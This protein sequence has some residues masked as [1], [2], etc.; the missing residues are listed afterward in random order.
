M[1][2]FINNKF[3]L[4]I[5]LLVA[6]ILGFGNSVFA[7]DFTYNNNQYSF[8]EL[9]LFT[10]Y[11]NYNY[12]VIIST[13]TSNV[14]YVC[15]TNDNVLYQSKYSS[16]PVLSYSKIYNFNYINNT[17]SLI[18]SNGTCGLSG[19][20]NILW[21]DI[22]IVNESGNV[23]FQGA[24]QEVTPETPEI[25]TTLVEQATQ[26]EMG[27]TLLETIK[28]YLIYLVIFVVSMLAIWKAIRFLRSVLRTS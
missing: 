1:K 22:D 2:N 23:V 8:N 14:V 13:S 7:V 17:I 19:Y 3:N 28:T 16:D 21:S 12:H 24:P 15:F 4:I 26:A 6:L 10:D 20:F 9:E 25:T 11:N 5:I 18:E 27:E